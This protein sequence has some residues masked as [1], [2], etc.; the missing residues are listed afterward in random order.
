MDQGIGSND[1]GPNPCSQEDKEVD[2]KYEISNETQSKKE[3]F[4][5]Q[6][7]PEKEKITKRVTM[8]QEKKIHKSL[9]QD[10]LVAIQSQKSPVGF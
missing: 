4:R 3:D 8:R 6:K 5:T 1:R 9:N 7:F 10:L 2:M